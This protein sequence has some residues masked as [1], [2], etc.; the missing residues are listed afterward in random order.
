M[1]EIKHQFTGGKMN[2]DVDE[3][4]VPNGE[5]RDAMN[6]QVSTS[7]GSDVGTIQNILGNTN[8]CIN[9][10]GSY[11]QDGSYVVGSIADEK[12]DSLYW[13][14]SGPQGTSG[15]DLEINETSSL[16]DLI[17]RLD[18]SSRLCDP[19][20]V[21]KYAFCVGINEDNFGA[22]SN[23]ISGLSG[24][25]FTQV[26]AGMTATGYGNNINLFG[27]TQ[28]I[29][30][31][32]IT[33]LAVNYYNILSYS[34]NSFVPPE[35]NIGDSNNTKMY[36]RGFWDDVTY[37]YTNIHYD[38]LV[39][40]TGSPYSQTNLPPHGASQFWIPLSD[41]PG[42]HNITPG[43]VIQNV[44]PQAHWTASIPN[45]LSGWPEIT[46]F[47]IG[48]GQ[49][50]NHFG[51]PISAWIITVGVPLG[52]YD[53]GFN[54]LY[55]CWEDNL[56]NHY[57]PN[58]NSGCNWPVG[59]WQKAG[60]FAQQIGEAEPFYELEAKIVP[61][62]VVSNT[63][64]TTNAI[65]VNQFNGFEWLDE[66]YNV[67]YDTDGNLI[68][69]AQLQIDN[70]IGSGYCFPPNSCVDPSSIIDDP[71]F[72]P[73]TGFYD[74]LLEIVDCDTGNAV[75]PG[76]IIEN[77]TGRPITFNITGNTL[78]GITLNEVVNFTGVD[79]ICFES[80]RVL[81]FDRNKLI[82][83]VDVI[84]DVLLW[85]DNFTEPKKINITRS[86][87]GTDSGGE[88]HTAIVNEDA[89]FDL[90]NNYN[91]IRE[92]NITVIRKTPKNALNLELSDG[93]DPSLIYAGVTRVGTSSVTSLIISSS[94][95]NV[96]LDFSALQVG[97][98][99]SFFILQDHLGSSSMDFE[100][101]QGGYLLLNEFNNNIAPNVP[102][103]NWTIRGLITGW[104]SN[105]FVGVAPYVKV[106]I[107]VVGINGTPGSP[108]PAI[109]DSLEYIVDLEDT[110]PVIF[111]DKFPRFSY[112]YRYEDGEYSTFAPWSEVAFLPSGFNYEPKKGWNTGMLN[113]VKSIKV[114]G[115]HKTT[116]G[117]PLG[118]DI[119]EVDILY[120]EDSS[121]NVY[122]VQTISP[123]D[124]LT[125]QNT[126]LPWYSNEYL[127]KSETIKGIIP[128]NQLLRSWDNVP[129]K[130]L[131]QS[132]SGNRVIYANYEQNFDLKINGQSYKPDFGNSLTT[133]AAPIS[134]VPK[135]S[136]K[137][138]RD[139]KLGVVF[140]DKY[141]RETPV[142]IGE[143]GGFRVEKQNSIDAN[144][145]K[146]RLK[147]E[148]PL[149]MAYYK[150]YIKET[151]NE[152]YNLAMD[153]WYNAEDG[154]IWLAFPSSDRNKIDLDTSLY[155]KRG[156]EGDE[157]VI[158]NS[159]KYK[160]LAI[161][162]EAPDFIKT[163]RVRIGQVAHL[164]TS[165]QIFG[166]PAEP[167][168]QAPSVG[169]V[170][171]TLDYEQGNFYGTSLSHMEDIVEDIYV[172]FN[173]SSD[174]SD[175]YKI[176]EIT[177]NRDLSAVPST[178]NPS[179]YYITLDAAFKDDINFI[180]DDAANPSMINDDTLLVF[181]KAVIE[182]KP[183]FDGRFFAK[184][185]NDGKIQTQITD[186]SV[187]TNYIETASKTI[188]A[189][190]DDDKLRDISAVA[191]YKSI[192][193]WSRNFIT[194]DYG[195]HYSV[196]LDD[197]PNGTNPGGLN[198]NHLAAREVYFTDTSHWTSPPNSSVPLDF[199]I[200]WRVNYQYVD[201]DM[202]VW[203]IDR[204]TKKYKVNT[205]GASD[206]AFEWLDQ[207]SMNDMFI[208]QEMDATQGG[209]TGVSGDVG[210]GIVHFSDHSFIK[211]GFGGFDDPMDADWKPRHA[212]EGCGVHHYTETPWDS[213]Y[214]VG[215]DNPK[216][217]DPITTKFVGGLNA[218]FLFRW[219]EDPTETIYKI[220]G[221]TSYQR[222]AR[223][224][225]VDEGQSCS[226][227]LSENNPWYNSIGNVA[228][229]STLLIGSPSSYTKTF[230]FKVTP[231]MSGWDPSGGAYGV[232]QYM[233]NGLHLG[234]GEF[235]S[236]TVTPTAVSNLDSIITL[237]DVSSIKVG[238]SV[239]TNTNIPLLSKVTNVDTLNSTITIDPP[240]T[241]S[242]NVT[243]A[244]EAGFTIR[245]VEA[246]MY[247]VAGNLL[248]PRENYIVVDNKTTECSNGNTLKPVYNL[249]KGMKL[250]R[251]NI[252]SNNK[253]ADDV[254]IKEIEPH[255][256]G[257]KLTLAGYKN[258]LN[259]T[260]AAGNLNATGAFVIGERLKFYQVSMNGASNFTEF[261][262]ENT[263]VNAPMSD[264]GNNELGMIG[265]VG[266]DMMF[267]EPISEYSDGG[268]LPENP[269]IWETEP[270][271]DNDLDIYYEIS[272]NNPTKLNAQTINSAIPMQSTV[273]GVSGNGSAWSNVYVTFNSFASG[274]E[275]R[276]S[277]YIWV[278][279]GLAP[280]GTIPL[281][282]GD[283]LLI[284]KP[285]GIRFSVKV[286][287]WTLDPLNHSMAK[288]FMLSNSY[289]AEH[290][291]NWHNCYSFGNGVESNR[292]KD[293]FNNPFISNG[294]KASTTLGGDYKKERRK[295]GLI[296]SGI[297]NSTSG[298]NNLNQF[299]QA[300]KITKDV[301]PIYGS[302]QK[303]HSKSTADG[304]LIVLCEDRILK[305]LANKDA[306]FNADGNPQLTASNNVLGQ[307][308]PFSG[309]F[310]ISKN[311]ESFASESYRAYFTD[312]VRGA[313][314]R[315][316]K[317]GLT[318]ISNHGMKD[319]FKDNLKL[320]SVLTGSH[321]NK[322][323]E[324]NITLKQVVEA[325]DFP[326][327][328]TVSFREDVKGWVSFK[329][330]VPDS[331]ISCAN[332]YYTFKGGNPWLHH[333]EK[334]N[335]LGKE[336][337]RNT[338]YNIPKD[339]SFNV[340]LNDVP[341]SVKSFNTINY[342]GSQS[343]VNQFLID[344]TTGLSDGEY[345]NLHDKKGWHVDHI[346]TD[347]EVGLVDEFI[348]KEGKWFNYIKGK[349]IQLAGQ[350]L[351]PGE[352]LNPKPLSNFDLSSFSVQGLGRLVATP[353]SGAVG[354]CTDAT[355]LNYDANAT[356]DDG[357]CIYPIAG[358]MDSTASNYDSTANTDDGSCVWNG[359]TDP[360]ALNYDATAT[361]D[362]GS[363]VAIVLGCTDSSATN[364]NSLAN[365]DNGT[366]IPFIYGCTD[367]TA[368]NY[369]STANTDD[370]SCITTINGCTDPSYIEYNALANTDDGS[371][372]TLI[373]FG[374]VVPVA[375]NFSPSA[376]VDDGSCIYPIPGCMD[377]GTL[378]GSIYF[379]QVYSNYN[380][381]ANVDDGSCID[382]VYGCTLVSG[383]TNYN[384]LATCDDSSC[385]AIVFGCTNPIATNYNALATDDDGSC[386]LPLIFGCTDPTMF[387]YDASANTDNGS[388]VAVVLGCIDPAEFNYNALANTDDGS[389]VPYIFGCTDPT[390][391]NLD[392]L[393][394][395][396]NGTCIY[397][398]N[399]CTD[400]TALNY[401][402]AT[403]VNPGSTTPCSDGVTCDDGS[404]VY[405]FPGCM[406]PTATNYSSAANVDC[407]FN[408]TPSAT[409]TGC[410]CYTCTVS[411][412]N[413]GFTLSGNGLYAT[414][415]TFNF[416]AG[417][418]QTNYSIT[419]G[420]N[421]IA[422]EQV[423]VSIYSGLDTIVYDNADSTYLLDGVTYAF[424]ITSNCTNGDGDDCTS[425][426]VVYFTM[427]IGYNN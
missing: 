124:I 248:I 162:N 106:E 81:N 132:I 408:T 391:L 337:G 72:D 264:D 195:A 194:V 371:C 281:A 400:A 49:V 33:T 275:I 116:W 230:G 390:A 287:G 108:D 88:I 165:A 335:S 406:D 297:Y 244:F 185:E 369:D 28:I 351:F 258:P 346:F 76:V 373:V 313:V 392:A 143:T 354:A 30:I 89:G 396:D 423:P 125:D 236:T 70:N 17:V 239:G 107:E 272:E 306:L 10:T 417:G 257:W 240:A 120:K 2:K 150:F 184:I 288:T 90:I 38:S 197:G 177:S 327:G 83:G 37:R 253:L 3:R 188:Y 11:I 171:F 245:V 254:V 67:L 5:Y 1:P 228:E 325:V 403:A 212:S 255:V 399:G 289:N 24:D 222:N 146:V 339:S 357:S 299:I 19:I 172:Q 52:P 126:T 69:G 16:K 301:N 413:A 138:L 416:P 379:P 308:V 266:Y 43:S 182:N 405:P 401:D 267:M 345:Y 27:P 385:I 203:F 21:D 80:E 128:S 82:T 147:G 425:S 59:I 75:A 365:V 180:F 225:R 427:T 223:F 268:N 291:L 54:R 235:H 241:G 190:E 191:L 71:L 247:G 26:T 50:V 426:A 227:F 362:D 262:T 200:N 121:P 307:A 265:A 95:A 251:Y 317:D 246:H 111:E 61:A 344:P 135:R 393:A 286:D 350:Y 224:G 102:L 139:Y 336:I 353:S 122:L 158:E 293:T 229:Q 386:I 260:D 170:S 129:K 381:L 298:V 178:S 276:V 331:A 199:L 134:A 232:G 283:I 175:Q 358:C 310:G 109:S 41:M 422:T 234:E 187:G 421:I 48:F 389:C 204:S 387:N 186:D 352:T 256:N 404:C 320:N 51:I 46:V 220:E 74:G 324:Y 347:K 355:A 157:N 343:K 356:I 375:I 141:G 303:I 319:W 39:D 305:I 156:A 176:S 420:A 36:I 311:P 77:T 395:T 270:K 100:W 300:E 318:A 20:F 151:S 273:V 274:Q 277:E 47:D 295:T 114:K 407:T 137:S 290:D 35:I 130:A 144:R 45:A 261:N 292:I 374:C 196:S 96:N 29:G 198:F 372:A 73:A 189:L 242:I 370:G 78:E 140:T 193:G 79:T 181:S 91:P 208:P 201:Q 415:L 167:L 86:A 4:L 282:V 259:T 12:N 363:C 397:C 383:Q 213:F 166:I 119:V 205:S 285:S 412:T 6:I 62:A 322:K 154:N 168:Y 279:P 424:Q 368:T 321:D 174:S 366:C 341:G 221:Q 380:P 332:E 211:L 284:T 414:Q 103:A 58:G 14:V 237:A 68:T 32:S 418:N 142:L 207:N 210:G 402:C 215:M 110:E 411:L 378:T 410:C 169:Q 231:S 85:T 34:G 398:I 152:Y 349:E 328:L 94:N 173:S 377:D 329:S 334:F 218:G 7:E 238:M 163:R 340:I 364:Y 271:K 269:F 216:W 9:Y 13:L 252:D 376:N 64:T 55:N 263:Q 214:G 338:F 31:G 22:S 419:Q 131:A 304:D 136:I 25:L 117:S 367:A 388:C 333:V 149:E 98:T 316:S 15:Q 104:P 280:D 18:V 112:R 330:F 361:Y 127:I 314:V 278:G 97:D 145:L 42:Q 217:D 118:K 192:G 202:G 164:G 99:V 8:G 40:T 233:T 123:I 249:H 384:A 179:N 394:N 93:R 359:C 60:R 312:K 44:L 382:C 342:E 84:D 105:S 348:E 113:N 326:N 115:F 87:Q 66:I 294:V 101:Q 57:G 160:V 315:L 219:K 133:W 206:N 92:E 155:F 323:N 153:R 250:R 309:N 302:I 159:T 409:A 56:G 161:E 23:T 63:Y 360:A 226:G 296:Y 209:Y 183:R 65:N 243:T 53:N 148:A